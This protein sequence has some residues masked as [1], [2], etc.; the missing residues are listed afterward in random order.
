MFLVKKIFFELSLK[1]Q[2]TLISFFFFFLLFIL[3]NMTYFKS[4]WNF[5][6]KT[7]LI[8]FILVSGVHGQV[9]DNPK[10]TQTIQ[11]L[12]NT[13]S[14]IPKPYRCPHPQIQFYLYTRYVKK[15]ITHV[16]LK[17][18][19]YVRNE[20]EFKY[21]LRQNITLLPCSYVYSVP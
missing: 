15:K 11:D 12:Y 2:V 16:I 9:L 10:K 13:S 20:V 18:I 19:F 5:Y 7:T 14:C 17:C 3:T 6:F 4:K 21:F 1:K 8:T